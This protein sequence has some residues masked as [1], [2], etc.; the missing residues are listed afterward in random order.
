MVLIKE[1]AKRKRLEECEALR[2]R[3]S[4]KTRKLIDLYNS[5]TAIRKL[6]A[7]ETAVDHL[8]GERQSSTALDRREDTRRYYQQNKGAIADQQRKRRQ[9][10]RA[11]AQEENRRLKESRDAADPPRPWDA[12]QA[13]M[14]E[15]SEE[16]CVH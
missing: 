11:L 13:R 2:E 6:H 8:L 10:L 12:F 9:E 14:A 5:T 3:L 4:E 15:L 1:V 16:A 7:I